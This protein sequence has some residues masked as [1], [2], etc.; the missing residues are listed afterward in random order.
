MVADNYFVDL[1]HTRSKFTLGYLATSC[2]TEHLL[3]LLNVGG[4]NMS[5]VTSSTVVLV[6]NVEPSSA[7]L[8]RIVGAIIH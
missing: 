1:T 4:A 8:L 6:K 5:G 7:G 3:V 2:V